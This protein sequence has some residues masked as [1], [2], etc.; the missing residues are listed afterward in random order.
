MIVAYDCTNRTSF[1]AARKKWLR[2]VRDYC[3]GDVIT[4]L[5]ATKSDMVSQSRVKPVEAQLL[6]SRTR[7]TFLKSSAF[8]NDNIS[9][10]FDDLLKRFV[11]INATRLHR[12]ASLGDVVKLK[13]V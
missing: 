5:T 12:A 13:S 7:A 6:C 10:I 2:L 4:I 11:E 3:R 8:N 1:S 9:A